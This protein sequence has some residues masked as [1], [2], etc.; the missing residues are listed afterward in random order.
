MLLGSGELS[1]E[2]GCLSRLLDMKMRDW[3]SQN[4]QKYCLQAAFKKYLLVD[5][6]SERIEEGKDKN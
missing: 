4:V 6:K 2:F 5:K 3:P 1:S